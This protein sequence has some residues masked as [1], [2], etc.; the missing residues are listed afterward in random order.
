MRS[1]TSF[2]IANFK[3]FTGT[4]EFIAANPPY[5]VVIDYYLKTKLEARNPVKITVTDKA[6]NKIRELNGPGEAGINRVNWDLRYDAPAQPPRVTPPGGAGENAEAEAEAGGAGRGGGGGGGG[7]GPFGFANRGPSVDPG[8]YSVAI[9]AA[10]KNE[11]KAVAVEEDPRITLAA[12]DR[13]KR[14]QA[15]TRLYGMARDAETGRRKIVAI[16]TSLT[17]LTDSWKR[18][19]ASQPPEA[20]KKAADDLLARVKEVAGH[21]EVDRQGGLGSA[22][23][24]LTYTPPPLNQKI[25][26]LMGSLDGYAAAPTDRQLTDIDL[27]SAE[28][29]PALVSVNKLANE[30]VP[31]LNKMMAGAG[32]PYVSAGPGGQ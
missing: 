24:P 16:R 13:A 19:G 11:S 31:R 26:R 3:G 20:V 4:R 18:P 7:G 15:L 12:A 1:G 5:G 8:E 21:F 9:A 17:T 25:G 32:V 22:G 6:G 29:A 27:A 2:H 10:G 28:L 14:R 23:P 30:D